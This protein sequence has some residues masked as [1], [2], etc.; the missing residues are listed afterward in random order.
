MKEAKVRLR[1][2]RGGSWDNSPGNYR[3]V[4]RHVNYPENRNIYSGFRVVRVLRTSNEGKEEET[5]NINCLKGIKC[6][7]CGYED[8]FQ[9]AASALFDVTDEG[10]E[11]LGDVEWSD[12][13]LIVCKGCEYVGKVKQFSLDVKS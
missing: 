12:D 4:Y 7:K 13:S 5:A 9:I 1:V 8:R 11:C 3:S 2:L 10:T 6:P